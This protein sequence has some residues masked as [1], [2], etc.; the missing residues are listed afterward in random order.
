MKKRKIKEKRVKEKQVRVRKSAQ[1]SGKIAY[2]LIGAFLIPV[3]LMIVLGVLSYSSAANSIA[4]QYEESISGSVTTVSEYCELL[5]SNIE[6]KAT[7]L[8]INESFATYYNKYAGTKS[9][10][11]SA[12]GRTVEGLLQK[13]RA[14]SEHIHSYSAFSSKGGN[15]TSQSFPIEVTAYGVDTMNIL[16]QWYLCRLKIMPSPILKRWIRV[17]DS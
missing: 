11:A 3:F 12:Y 4:S 14:S 10:E 7:E 6:D 5:C 17:R 13:A 8:V 1:K 16:I 9:T 2:Q 15:Y